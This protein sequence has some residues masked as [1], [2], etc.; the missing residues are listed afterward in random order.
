M[1]NNEKSTAVQGNLLQGRQGIHIFMSG[2]CHVNPI[3]KEALL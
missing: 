3:D 1:K 2:I